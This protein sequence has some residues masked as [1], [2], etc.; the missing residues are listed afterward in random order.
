MIINYNL[1]SPTPVNESSSDEPIVQEA[2]LANS[3]TI[4]EATSPTEEDPILKDVIENNDNDSVFASLDI[5]Q[6]KSME[7]NL[8]KNL[9]NDEIDSLPNEDSPPEKYVLIYLS[10]IIIIFFT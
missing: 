2:T 10:K 9:S 5:P 8:N 1:S 6:D 3:L 7:T 4:A